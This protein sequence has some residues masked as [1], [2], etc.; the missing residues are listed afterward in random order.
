MTIENNTVV[1]NCWFMIYAGSGISMLGTNNFDSQNNVYKDLA[2]NNKVFNNR[3]YMPWGK[4]KRMSDGN[5]IILDSN[6]LPAEGKSYLGRTLLQNNL[7]VDNG[8]SGIHSFRSHQIDIVNNTAYYNGATPQLKWGQIFCQSSD[9]IRFVNNI[10]VA[11]PGQPINTV[12]PTLVDKRNTNIVR[13]NNLYVS[14]GIDFVPGTDDLAADPMFVHPTFDI[15]DADFPRQ[16][17][18]PRDR[19]RHRDSLLSIARPRRSSSAPLR[20]E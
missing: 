10:A 1:N 18:K 16:A 3:C 5:G 14:G 17:G 9:D 7:C 2:R 15:N 12:G 20:D 11:R 6:H 4:I 19:P 8:G 13:L